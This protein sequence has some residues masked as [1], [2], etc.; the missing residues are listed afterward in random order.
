MQ[1][2]IDRVIQ[3]AAADLS[4]GSP[5]TC[6]RSA[7]PNVTRTPSAADAASLPAHHATTKQPHEEQ[8]TSALH[9]AARPPIKSG[10]H[11]H[12]RS[13]TRQIR[14]HRRQ[15]QLSNSGAGVAAFAPGT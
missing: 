5:N 2:P 9:V 11:T 6:C 13:L 3:P 12:L 8:L 1:Q 10:R 7:S 14:V 15:H 4:T